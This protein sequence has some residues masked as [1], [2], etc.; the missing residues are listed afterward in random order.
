MAGQLSE[1]SQ[2]TVWS[3][4][5]G[6]YFSGTVLSHLVN[7][8]TSRTFCGKRKG[9]MTAKYTTFGEHDCKVCCRAA[10]RLLRKQASK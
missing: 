9:Q 2:F 4:L 5:R 8:G 10:T 6:N 1:F 7:P 3:S